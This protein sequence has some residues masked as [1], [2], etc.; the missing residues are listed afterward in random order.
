MFYLRKR[1]KVNDEKLSIKTDNK[2]VYHQN[3]LLKRTRG[4]SWHS[5]HLSCF[6]HETVLWNRGRK[7]RF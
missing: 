2:G 4:T 5:S 3:I 7:R 6:K 1:F